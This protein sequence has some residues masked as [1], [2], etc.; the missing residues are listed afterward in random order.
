MPGA[1]HPM[2]SVF[3]DTLSPNLRPAAIEILHNYHLKEMITFRQKNVPPKLRAEFELSEGEWLQVLD[4]VI[5]TK[6]SY[7]H[8]SPLMSLEHINL[9]TKIIGFALHQPNISLKQAAAN[10]SRSHRF[11]SNWLI[12]LDTIKKYKESL[13]S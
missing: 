8:I 2:E 13:K 3:L 10:L 5:L 7:F 6:V 4:K 12:R 1:N 11:F 9:L